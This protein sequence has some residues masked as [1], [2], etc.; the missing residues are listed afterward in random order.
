[1]A[2][3]NNGLSNGVSKL[4]LGD[5]IPNASTNDSK[6]DPK[7]DGSS[8]PRGDTPRGETSKKKSLKKGSAGG[9][10]SKLGAAAKKS[11]KAATPKKR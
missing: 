11:A 2:G 3:D 9:L 7:D 5:V 10:K 8:T 1:M 6:E 4:S